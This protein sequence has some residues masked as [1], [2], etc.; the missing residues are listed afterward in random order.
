MTSAAKLVYWFLEHRLLT[1]GMGIMTY[2]T[3]PFD[4]TVDILLLR[5]FY[6]TNQIL[7]LT[8]TSNTELKRAFLKKLVTM[9]FCMGIMAKGTPS[10]EYRSMPEWARQPSP[11]PCMTVETEITYI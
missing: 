6:L 5:S 2:D 3:A 11:L 1:G 8:V 4:D 9:I 10:N 7:H